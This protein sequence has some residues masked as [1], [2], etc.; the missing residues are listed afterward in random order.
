[1]DQLRKIAAVLG[2]SDLRA[3]CEMCNIDWIASPDLQSIVSKPYAKKTWLSLVTPSCP[4]PSQVALDL[5]SQLLIYNHDTRLT[6]KEAM[7]HAFFDAV[8][9]RV[10]TELQQRYHPTSV[11]TTNII[12]PPASS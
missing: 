3:Y 1:M 9:D 7:A 10:E 6:A 4:I 11:S 12:E 5:L 2:T 8:R